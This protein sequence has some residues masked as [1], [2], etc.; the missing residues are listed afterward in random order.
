MLRVNAVNGAER[1]CSQH[2][3]F[4]CFLVGVRDKLFDRGRQ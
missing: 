3:L 1:L 2:F 4:Y